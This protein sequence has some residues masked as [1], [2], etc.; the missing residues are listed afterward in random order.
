M[1]YLQ[2]CKHDKPL[3]FQTCSPDWERLAEKGWTKVLSRAKVN[4]YVAPTGVL[5]TSLAAACDYARNCEL[6]QQESTCVYCGAECLLGSVCTV[7]AEEDCGS[8]LDSEYVDSDDCTSDE[9]GC[10]FDS[11]QDYIPEGFYLFHS[12]SLHSFLDQL[13]R[14][15][16][17]STPDCRGRL[18]LQQ[19]RTSG[20]GA[21]MLKAQLSCDGCLL[22][23]VELSTVQAVPGTRRNYASLATTMSFLCSGNPP[24][25]VRKTLGTEIVF[26]SNS[27]N[28]QVK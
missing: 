3:L 27:F 26:Y 13:N 25:L 8:D 28:K 7:C 23:Q 19:V 15:S 21:G 14:T 18:V 5:F 24:G 4:N 1:T 22:R 17:C 20:M 11:A 9:E 6:S 16:R 2:Y 10:G 12:Q